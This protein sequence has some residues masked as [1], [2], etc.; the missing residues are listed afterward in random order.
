MNVEQIPYDAR[1]AQSLKLLISKPIMML[2]YL[3]VSSGVFQIFFTRFLKPW[4]L[5]DALV[6]EWG[7]GGLALLPD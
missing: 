1:T 4:I 6:Q 7:E 2:E 3:V 5:V